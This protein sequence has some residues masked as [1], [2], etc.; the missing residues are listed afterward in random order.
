MRQLSGH[1]EVRSL[2]S[3]RA[4]TD[5][6]G[7]EQEA[8]RRLRVH[9]QRQR[10]VIQHRA[11]PRR[12]LQK[13]KFIHLIS[14]KCSQQHELWPPLPFIVAPYGIM[15]KHVLFINSDDLDAA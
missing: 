3:P 12:A 13:L 14:C 4:E 5:A 1:P 7:N 9:G 10:H 2:E 6:E 11:S 8:N 15:E